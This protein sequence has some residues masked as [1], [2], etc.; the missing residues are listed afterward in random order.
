M[1]CCLIH[2]REPV[3]V[4]LASQDRPGALLC[5]QDTWNLLYLFHLSASMKFRLLSK[6]SLDFLALGK[7][8]IFDAVSVYVLTVKSFADRIQSIEDQLRPLCVPFEFVFQHD[9]DELKF[10]PAPLQ[11]SP[12]SILTWP[13]RSIAAKHAEAWRRSV[14]SGLPYA[15]VLEDDVLLRPNFLTRL[16]TIL[17]E[18]AS[19]QPGFLINLGGANSRVPLALYRNK[20]FFYPFPMET[21]EGYISDQLGIRRRLEWLDKNLVDRSADHMTRY[22]D[23]QMQTR[24]FWPKDALVEQGSL[25]GAFDSSLDQGRASRTKAMLRISYESKKF[26]RRTVKQWIANVF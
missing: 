3:L 15:L 8:N 7:K 2:F 14:D 24:H 6:P 16:A 4:E 20:S 17:S 5:T 9:V 1:A 22:I 26:R 13:E 12:S 11:F 19:L 25:F 18:A 10:G 21:S 23:D